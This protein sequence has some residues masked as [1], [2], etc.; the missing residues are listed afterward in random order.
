MTEKMWCIVDIDGTLLPWT[1][2]R[3]CKGS[4]VAELESAPCDMDW[5]TRSRQEKLRTARCTVTVED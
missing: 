2:R 1:I 3:T 4:I 5:K